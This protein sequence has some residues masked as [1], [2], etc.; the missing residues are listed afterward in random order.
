MPQR[1]VL[2]IDDAKVIRLTVKSALEKLEMDIEVLELGNAEDLFRSPWKFQNLD[3]IIL[4][5]DLPGMDG[6]TALQTLK[7]EPQWAGIPVIMLTGHSDP[8]LVK[9]AIN[10][11]VSDYIRKPF[12]ADDIA[13]R[14][15]AAMNAPPPQPSTAS[16]MRQKPPMNVYYAILL[17]NTVTE[18]PAGLADLVTPGDHFAIRPTGTLTLV[19][20]FAYAGGLPEA[21]AHA[22]EYLT[23][24]NWPVS[25]VRVVSSREEVTI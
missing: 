9:R 14:A 16:R 15:E 12:T 20:P 19:L 18:M 1:R 4:D 13:K 3:L 17:L 5:I 21:T 22:R 2:V 10:F 8:K 7:I 23:A 11:G 25:F 6:I 24:K